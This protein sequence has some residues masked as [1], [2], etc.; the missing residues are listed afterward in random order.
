MSH[1]HCM[2]VTHLCAGLRLAAVS[3]PTK[4]VNGQVPCSLALLEPGVCPHGRDLTE[5]P[6]SLT[7]EVRG[8][9]GVGMYG[10]LLFHLWA[11][12]KL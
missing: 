4:A 6:E 11:L 8:P 2:W 12:G 7:D 9:R 5:E 10:G 1:L 3:F